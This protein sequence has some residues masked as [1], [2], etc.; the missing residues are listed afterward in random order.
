MYLTKKEAMK[1]NPEETKRTV[2][3]KPNFEGVV[4]FFQ[5]KITI[6]C[7]PDHQRDSAAIAFQL[8]SLFP[9]ATADQIL[10]LSRGE[11]YDE[12]I[13]VGD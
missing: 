12:V 10:R 13:N 2:S 6:E 7:I 1:T 3:I 11:S 5:D 8:L 4:R 9:D